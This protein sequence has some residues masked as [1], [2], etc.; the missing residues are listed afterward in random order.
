MPF[1][2]VIPIFSVIPTKVGI[3]H[4]YENAFLTP[5][6]QQA[7]LSLGQRPGDL[8]ETTVWEAIQELR[9]EGLVSDGMGSW[10][11]LQIGE[12]AASQPGSLSL[13]KSSVVG[14]ER[15]TAVGDNTFV[16]GSE[17][18]AIGQGARACAAEEGGEIPGCRAAIAL[19]QNAAAI[20]LKAIAIGQETTA[21]HEN[22]IAIGSCVSTTAD[23][24]VIIGDEDQ[25]VVLKPLADSSAE[26]PEHRLVTVAKTGELVAQESFQIKT[27]VDPS[28]GD[29]IISTGLD[30]RIAGV[31]SDID[32]LQKG[33][34]NTDGKVRSLET[35]I[36]RGL[37]VSSALSSLKFFSEE[38]KRFSVSAGVG[39][40]DSETAFGVGVGAKIAGTE[41]V[42]VYLTG[43]FGFSG[44]ESD[45]SKQGGGSLNFNF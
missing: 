33:L 6:Q 29:Y 10:G 23:N 14:A 7:L 26:A 43:Q 40:S 17:S 30:A 22:S 36:K 13:G 20:Q 27:V 3:R 21:M 39:Y 16:N 44:F 19:G 28:E 42:S 35:K 8:E 25:H 12:N 1:F 5:E 18:V 4:D 11:Q 37:A 9:D 34:Q 41:K 38:D 15:G 45:D 24:Q 31:E 2:P 32:S